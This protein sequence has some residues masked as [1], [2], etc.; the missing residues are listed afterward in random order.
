MD[1]W[2]FERVGSDVV[3][4]LLRLSAGYAIAVV[5]AIAVGIP[6]G[7]NPTARRAAAPIVEF[8]RAIPPPALLP[9]AIV[10][11][12]VGNAMK[13]LIIAFVCLWPV[14][15]NTID[16][17]RGHRP[18]AQRHHA[19]LRR[20]RPRPRLRLVTLPAAAPQ[21]FAGMRTSLS[22]AVILMVISEMVASTNGIGFFVLQSQ[23]SFDDPRDVVR[24]PAARHPRLRAQRHLHHGRTPRPGVAPRSAQLMLEIR[25]LSK[26]YG[27]THAIGDLDFTIGEREFVCVVGPSGCGKTTLLK[28]MSGLL[29]PT[30]GE[31]VLNGTRVTRPPEEMALVFQEYSRSLM[32][33]M[34]VRKNVALPL[35]HKGQGASARRLVDEAVEAV[36]LTKFIDRYPWQLSG[37]MQ[38]RVAIARALAYQPQ[39]LLMDE[40]FASVDAQTRADLEDLILEVRERYDVTIVFVTHDIDESVYLSDRIVVLTPSPTTVK[41]IL[42][43]GLPQPRDQVETKE[44]PEFAHLRAHVYRLIKRQEARVAQ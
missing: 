23:R 19:R 13:V 43:V 29:A 12:G 39:I 9:L 36:G 31:V 42:E 2:V 3:P 30:S 44:L 28:C 10:V 40:P 1:T 11:I 4:S 27:D 14:L 35:R 20:P 22:L 38:Q 18:D 26:S 24:D 25:H 8:L 7:L 41:E 32:P 34:S 37:G 15:L 21:I 33:W 17:I 5:V 16:G 6:L